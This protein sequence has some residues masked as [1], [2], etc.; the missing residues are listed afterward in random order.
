MSLDLISAGLFGMLS[1]L[2]GGFVTYLLT[3]S[4]DKRLQNEEVKVVYSAI[5]SDLKAIKKGFEL[6]EKYLPRFTSKNVYIAKGINLTAPAGITLDIEELSYD[7]IR[8]EDITREDHE[9]NVAVASSGQVGLE[10][11]NR[12]NL[13][14]R[15]NL[16]NNVK[17]KVPELISKLEKY[18]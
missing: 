8:I 4:R 17:I 1:T 9:F 7:F 3:F 6:S 2:V 16:I 5:I 12:A 18:T 10:Y 11:V 14:E 15:A 13:S